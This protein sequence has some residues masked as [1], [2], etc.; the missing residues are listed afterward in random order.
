MTRSWLPFYEPDVPESISYPDVPLT[1]FLSDSAQRFPEK[2]ALSFYGKGMTYQALDEA[3]NRF[4][5][6]LKIL[7]VQKG[8]CVG[9][10]LPNVPQ[11]V[12]AY[13]GVLKLGAVAVMTNPLYVA[14]EIRVQ[15]ADSGAKT[16]IALDFFYPRIEEIL[17]ET[18]LKNIILTSVR[19]AL[20][21]LLSLLY[22][23]K[24]R[25]EGQWVDIRKEPP[26]YDMKTLINSASSE[27]IAEGVTPD[28]L[29]ILQYTGGTTG[30]PK[31]VML[32]HRNLV[33]NAI[34]C[35]NWMPSLREGEERFLSVIPF[36]HVY[37]M[38]TCMNMGLFLG[39][40][41]I[42]QA[43][44]VTKDVLK[45]IH[46]QHPTIFMG[47]QAMY[48][49]INNFPSI[50][51]YD[52]S[53]IKACISGAGPLHQE[54]QRQFEGYTGGKLVEGYGLSEASPVT[55]ANP[56][57]GKRK[58]GT[59]GLPVSDT[60][61]K[62]VDEKDSEKTLGIGE[63]GELAVKGPQV[64]QGYW[65][66]AEETNKV[67]RDGWLYTGDMARMDE[68]GFFYI[69]DRK[70][71]MIKTKGENVYPREVEEVLF[72]HPK[73]QDAVVAGIPEHF[74]GEII[75]AYIV[76][77]EGETATE[78]DIL[79]FCREKLAKF[80][81]PKEVEFRTELPKTIIGKVLRRVLLEEEMKKQ[82]GGS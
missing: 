67:L 20:P 13:Y 30:T 1:Q 18:Q 42:L 52:L 34:Q 41:L 77:K 29:A 74:A 36:F 2:E 22:P 21:W 39:A 69:V 5:H 60:L 66:N 64:M 81:V 4:A 54:V 56:I 40:T 8:D 7:G 79:S 80:K 31:G 72:Q 43:R 53:S 32:S 38:S 23:L 71:D 14:S 49:A 6:A 33:V 62:V 27:P 50:K 15:M 73:I 76:L 37:G 16:L 58:A 44:F 25:R 55:H 17:K 45:A 10:M 78:D 75:K 3:T 65:N 51:E 35:R 19:D 47:I 63:I 11:C 59:I 61:A 9:I 82:Q 70:K 57:N 46:K 24:A 12:I 48:V 26:I 28:D 68:E